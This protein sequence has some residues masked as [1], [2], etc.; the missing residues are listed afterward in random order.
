MD[1]LG[2]TKGRYSV[3]SYSDRPIEKERLDMIL[4]AGNNA[5]TACN[6]QPQRVYVILSDEGREKVK[7]A[8]SY[9]YNAPCILM[10]CYD[11]DESWFGAGNGLGSIDATIVGT[12]MMLEAAEQ[13]IG[14]VWVAS[15]DPSVLADEFRLPS[16]M[17]P[18]SLIPIGYPSEGCKPGPN[19]YDRKA[20][21]ETVT[22]L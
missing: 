21:S 22:Y 6:A 11:E 1:F 17:V 4:E 20:I 3:R 7:K 16:N 15:F 12:H 5:P 18:V 19:H 9:H 13:G 14:S 8:T 2:L 10:I